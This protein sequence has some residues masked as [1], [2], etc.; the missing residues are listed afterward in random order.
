MKFID[1]YQVLVIMKFYD[2]KINIVERETMKIISSEIMSMT[3]LSLNLEYYKNKQVNCIH[4][5]KY[6]NEYDYNIT[7]YNE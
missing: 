2:I 3:D 6:D 1:L 5:M 4:S 7:L